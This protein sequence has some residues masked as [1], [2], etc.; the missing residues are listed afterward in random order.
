MLPADRN[1]SVGE[2]E[3]RAV[4][5]ALEC[6]SHY[7]EDAVSLELYHGMPKDIVSDRVPRFTDELFKE[8]CDTLQIKQ[9]ISVSFHHKTDDKIEN[10]SVCRVD[11]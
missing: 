8:F 2:Q 11:Q 7:R 3:L 10:E 1:Y 9:N 5:K 6:W 4:V